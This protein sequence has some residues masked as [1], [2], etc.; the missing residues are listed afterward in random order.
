MTLR[1]TC[2]I[3]QWKEKVLVVQRS[4]KM[5]LPLKWEFPGGK[6]ENGETE[7]ECIVREIKEELD[8]DIN[9][10]QRLHS[11]FYDYPN[12]SIEL[13]PFVAKQVG[14]QISLSEHADFKYCSKDE[15]LNLNWAEADIPIVKEYLY[16]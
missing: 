9:V 10:I 5:N 14:G 7:E 8:L 11:S 6:I 2:A 3:I 15:L 4:E 12:I 16:L 1:V 13:I